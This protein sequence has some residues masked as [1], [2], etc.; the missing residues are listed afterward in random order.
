M[1]MDP[2]LT[3]QPRVFCMHM[4]GACAW[5]AI[6]MQFGGTRDAC[7]TAAAFRRFMV[8]DERGAP[9]VWVSL[10]RLGW[11]IQL[12]ELRAPGG[13]LQACLV[14]REDGGFSVWVDDR[15]S[16]AE[17]N[18]PAAGQ[19]GP[20]AP[21]VRF[22]LAHELAHALFYAAG[23]PPVRRLPPADGEESFCDDVASLVL[24]PPVSSE[25]TMSAADI[26]TASRAPIAAVQRSLRWARPAMAR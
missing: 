20:D 19:R 22:R 8:P 21:L 15:P 10:E 7:K 16:P 13:G 26:A 14:P 23:R 12:R 17:L 4:H 1:Q 9:N 6:L 25:G 18:D 3:P 11:R 2:P 5:D 24:V